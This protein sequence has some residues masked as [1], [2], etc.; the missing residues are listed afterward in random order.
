MQLHELRYFLALCEALNFT[1]AAEIC[2]VTQP[3]LTRAIRRLEEKLGAPLVNRERGNTHLNEFGH[4]ML[5]HF[6]K[7]LREKEAAE[8][9]A[10]DFVSL[11]EVR[12]TVGLMCTIG[13]IGLVELFREFAQDHSGIS[14]SIKDGE[15]SEIEMQLVT[16]GID[17]AIYCRPVEMDEHVQSYHLFTERFVVA[18]SPGHPLTRLMAVRVGDLEGHRYLWRTNCEYADQIDSAFEAVGVSVEYPYDSDRDD[19]IQCMVLAGL[20][21]TLIP[22]FAVTVPGLV[23]RPLIEPAFERQV[24]LATIRGRPHLPMVRAFVDH[25]RRFPWEVS[26]RARTGQ[27]QVEE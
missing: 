26:L 4:V 1:R 5:P 27:C 21:F 24:I 13:P 10:R 6:R 8:R 22:E 16:G 7:M 20:G 3:A 15:A 2:N 12:L 23:T 11:K 25:V 18:I 19:W 17:V 14:L 9:R